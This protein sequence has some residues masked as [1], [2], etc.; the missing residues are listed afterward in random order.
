MMVDVCYEFIGSTKSYKGKTDAEI[1]DGWQSITRTLSLLRAE[2]IQRHQLRR[3]RID[4]GLWI[5]FIMFSCCVKAQI[6]VDLFL[7][8]SLQ[9]QFGS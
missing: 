8:Q 5:V 6:S 7:L 4:Y 9:R 1:T 3:V 2:M